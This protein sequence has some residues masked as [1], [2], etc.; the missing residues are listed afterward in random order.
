[1]RSALG[2]L[3]GAHRHRQAWT[4]DRRGVLRPQRARALPEDRARLSCAPTG[5]RRRGCCSCP[6]TQDSRKASRTPADWS[7]STSCST[8]ASRAL[9]VFEHELNEY[10]SVQVTRILHDFYDADP[11]RGHYGGGGLD[12][13]IG[14]QPMVWAQRTATEGPAWGSAYKARLAEFPRSMHV[15]CHGTSLQWNRTASRSIR[16]SR[17][18]GACR[19]SATTYKD[20]PDDL[21]NARFLQDRG[22]EI[23]E[24]AGALRITRS[25]VTEQQSSMH[26]LGTCRM[27]NDP[28]KSVDRQVSPQPRH[29]ESVRL[30]RQQPG[31]LRT[32]PADDDDSGAGVPRR[33][34]HRAFRKARRGLGGHCTRCMGAAA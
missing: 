13:R 7:A 24:A 2:Q 30:R 33:R 34:A 1:M 28:A 26:L 15:A 23:L 17:M 19:R 21:A 8:T 3:R 32:R 29:P 9:G 11:K 20:H 27:G 25:P 31:D 16:S 5:R 10:K 14:P 22:A 12:A 18:R 4:R 6:R